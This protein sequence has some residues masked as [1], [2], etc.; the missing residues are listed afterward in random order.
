MALDHFHLTRPPFNSAP[1]PAFHFEDAARRELLGA[2]QYALRLGDGVI[3]VTGEAGSGKT[4]LCGVLAERLAQ[5]SPPVQT[6][7]LGQPASSQ[8]GSFPLSSQDAVCGIARQLGLAP[9]GMRSDEVMR[10]LYSHLAAERAVGKRAVLLVEESQLLPA[11]TLETLRQLT[12]LNDGTNNLLPVV[13]LGTAELSNVLRQPRLRQLRERITLSFV[14]PPLPSEL[15]PELLAHRLRVA[16]HPDGALFQLDAAKLIARTAGA[17]LHVLIALADKSLSVA[18]Q[19]SAP[20]V[21]MF[22]VRDAIKGVPAQSAPPI[23]PP[24]PP[25]PPPPDKPAMVPEPQRPPEATAQ[26]T[27]AQAASAATEPAESAEAASIAAEPPPAV[28]PQVVLAADETTPLADAAPDAEAAEDMPMSTETARDVPPAL[29][30]APPAAAVTQAAPFLGDTP[31][32]AALAAQAAP[33]QAQ[34][35]QAELQPQAEAIPAPPQESGPVEPPPATQ[36]EAAAILQAAFQQAPVPPKPRPL[37]RSTMA[38]SGAMLA[39]AGIA[40][41]A[42]LL[43]PAVAP[44]S[45]A[46]PQ[47]A[48]PAK[49]AAS[50]A[51]PPVRM[52]LPPSDP[53]PVQPPPTVAAAAAP[54]GSAA[55][56]AAPQPSPEAA[57]HASAQTQT[58]ALAAAQAAPPPEKPATATAPATK[59]ASP[60]RQAS[61]LKQSLLASKTWLRDEPDNNFCVQIENFPAGESARAEKFLA[62]TRVTIGLSEV[63]SYPMLINGERRIAIVYGSFA[64]AKKVMQFQAELAERSGTHHKIRTI[65]GIRQAIAKAEGKKQTN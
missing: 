49:A 39:V 43:R 3:K 59:P 7:L 6:L 5:A 10:M 8:A 24:S 57:A 61:L 34:P 4:M 51:A 35:P 44:A 16:G 55:P 15:V 26:A 1:D 58:A 33:L 63:H 17:D 65:K 14:L 25:P 20:A 53:A 54:L 38:A 32:P 11:D 36:T 56:T 19:A 50:P 37:S 22:H 64:S 2:L 46:A 21:A 42:F 28:A 9:G 45:I 18:A 47:P 12:N 13:L 52:A 27:P 31:L 23:A 60:P 40:T 30:A 29:E 48:V 62:D 41:A